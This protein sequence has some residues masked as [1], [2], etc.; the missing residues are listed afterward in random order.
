MRQAGRYLP[1]YRTL[2][3]EQKSFLNL[4]FS[5]DKAT[6]VT[7]QPIKRFGF[8]AAIL[9]SDI[10][11]VPLALN[12]HVSFEDGVQL[13]SINI[14]DISV[15]E[16]HIK[17]RLEPI[18][19][20]ITHTRQR[21]QREKALI[22]F[23][24]APFTVA[25][26]MIQKSG[27]DNFKQALSFAYTR[28]KEFEELLDKITHA[29]T[30]Y[31]LEQ[32]KAGVDVVQVFESWSS[33]CPWTKQEEWL[34]FPLQRIIKGIR[35]TYPNFP[36]TSYIKGSG[37][38]IPRYASLSEVTCISL[39]ST[40]SLKNLEDIDC[41]VQGNLDPILLLAGGNLMRKTILDIKEAVR[42]RPFIF[43]LGHGVLP[44]TPLEHVEQLIR[45]VRNER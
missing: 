45:I 9:F 11:V 19:E 30:I 20:T 31:L 12:Q 3:S 2:R 21:L 43:N 4:V 18:F 10:L 28:T 34:L 38:F 17:K 16:S 8:D 40:F 13:G 15:N 44:D 7:L 39:D 23:A 22:G 35:K 14:R 27:K 36:I 5:P 26:Y 29:T 33:L 25:L 37:R 6:E 24:G 41:V 42:G 32:I 1:E